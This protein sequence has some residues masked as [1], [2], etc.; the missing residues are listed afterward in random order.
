MKKH[1]KSSLVWYTFLL[2]SLICLVIMTY[3]PTLTSVK[4]SFYNIS[5][6]GGEGTFVGLKN[7]QSLLSNSAFIRA[8][9]NTLIL[10]LYSYAVIPL[11]MVLASFIQS[12]GRSRLQSF[13]RIGFFV[14]N[15]ISTI[16]VIMVFRYVLLKNGGLLNAVL[17]AL[18]GNEVAIGWLTD[19]QI[20]K[21]GVSIMSIWQS[22]GYTMLICLAGLQSISQEL[23]EA[24]QM[25]RANA[26]E[27]WWHITVPNM[28]SIFAFLFVT[29][30]ISAFS[31]FTDLYVL[32]FN[33]ASG[34]SKSS[35]Q[36]LM[37]YI[38]Q[39]SFENPKFGFSS[40]G[41]LILFLIVLVITRINLKITKTIGER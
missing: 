29:G 17:S 4:Y 24:A 19:P 2:P 12:L 5:A 18:L 35:L 11:G 22:L 10:A 31:R 40:A 32:S 6:I 33:S 28:T 21:L 16:S 3:I 7:Y 8:L 20:N 30:T 26:F 39:F 41:V 1:L 34:G 27:R 9:G 15:V 38:Y 37:M 13:F 25:D 36:S 23:Y 14:P